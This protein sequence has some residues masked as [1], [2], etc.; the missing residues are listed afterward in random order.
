LTLAETKPALQL[1]AMQVFSR[2][3]PSLE[4]ATELVKILDVLP[5]ESPVAQPILECFLNILKESLFL[6]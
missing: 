3:K 4:H 6:Y 1:E 5:A 2:L